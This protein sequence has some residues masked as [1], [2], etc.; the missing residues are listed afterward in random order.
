MAGG[1]AL[2]G[3]VFASGSFELERASDLF[4]D[5]SDWGKGVVWVNGFNLGRYWRRGPQR[6]LFVPAPVLRTG[7]N[8]IIVFETSGATSATAR[9]VARPELGSTEE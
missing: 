6:T 5:T 1:T 7:Q 9:F 2:S 8:E 3:P 4:L